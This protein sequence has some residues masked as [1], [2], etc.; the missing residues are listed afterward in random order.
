MTCDRAPRTS[1]L[2]HAAAKI[3]ST[4]PTDGK[5]LGEVPVADAAAIHERVRQADAAYRAHWR[6]STLAERAELLRRLR[7]FVVREHRTIAEMVAREQGKPLIEAVA[8]EVF[9]ALDTL[10]FLVH[11]G[12]R[13]L[14]PRRAGHFQPFLAGRRASVH[15]RPFGVWAVIAPWN[16]PFSIP[17]CQIAALLFA[18]NA[19]A[20]KP[21]PLTPLVGDLIVDLFREAGFD[22][23]LVQI[24]HGGASEGERLVLEEAV[25]AVMFT[26]GLAGGRRVMELAARG[27][28]KVVLELGGKDP[29]IVCADADLE[30][31]ARG[32]A[33][34]AMMNAGQT[35]ASVERVYVDERVRGRF[36]DLL[37]REVEAIRLGDPLAESTDMGPLASAAQLDQ[38]RAQV[39]DARSRGAEVATGGRE[40]RELGPLFYAPTVVLRAPGRAALR[41]E[42]TF[43]PV[44]LVDGV[45]TDDEAARRANES[46]FGLTASVW[47][48]DPRRVRRLAER[49]EC[50][51]V[52]ANTHLTT[53]AEPNS[54][55][56][57]SKASGFGRTHG[58][59]GLLECVE[60]QYV[61]EEYSER[62][63]MWW[64]PYGERF[65]ALVGDVFTFLGAPSAR[66]RIAA[67]L[68]FVPQLG[69]LARHARLLRLGP[70]L[71]RYLR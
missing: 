63:E 19:V 9:P 52:T 3:T 13:I 10:S 42:E 7:R 11:R 43:G 28:K 66:V 49:L 24:V 46:A 17:F 65:R 71:V 33:W 61:D 37:V 20:F 2:M 38:V 14:R 25:R 70:G 15:L 12:P 40:R 1:S 57:G 47:S 48:R 16:Y 31:A 56:G 54:A 58:S 5:V 39:E 18:G 32:I 34:S 44:V 55:W 64:Y 68:R 62:P 51:V 67:L 59:H 41:D 60:P 36:V 27:P 45:P 26:G 23:D 30:R 35:C 4:S 50:G 6:G 8:S 21:S 53:F 29:A 69:Y 22:E